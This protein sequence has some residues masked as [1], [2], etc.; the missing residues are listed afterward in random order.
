MTTASTWPL[1]VERLQG[2]GQ[3]WEHE[4]MVEDLAWWDDQQRFAGVKRP[5]RTKLQERWA[6]SEWDARK[7]LRDPAWRERGNPPA[8]LQESSSGSPAVLQ[9][10][11]EP[12]GDTVGNPPTVLQPFSKNPP[13]ILLTRTDTPITPPITPPLRTST[14]PQADDWARVDI[15]Y[16]ALRRNT[17]RLLRF[18]TL[19]YLAKHRGRAKSDQQALF[20][21][22]KKQTVPDILKVFDFI[23]T[24]SDDRAVFYRERKCR[25][26]TVERKFEELLERADD[27]GEPESTDPSDYQ[28]NVARSGFDAEENQRRYEEAMAER[29]TRAGAR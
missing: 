17:Y 14:S 28:A 23:A 25:L 24:S 10:A 15:A 18:P 1:I 11:L 5:G 9:P 6:C 8:S 13:A 3:P 22:L 2:D 21:L 19:P 7:A 27:P 12:K 4:M 20:V 26:I 16:M 29:V